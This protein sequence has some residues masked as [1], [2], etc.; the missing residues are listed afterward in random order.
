[1]RGKTAV[2][3]ACKVC[4]CDIGLTR[5][6]GLKICLPCY[7][8]RVRE[9]YLRTR[10]VTRTHRRKGERATLTEMLCSACAIVK[11]V[12]DFNYKSA[13]CRNCIAAKTRRWYLEMTGREV[14]KRVPKIVLTYEQHRDTISDHYLDTCRTPPALKPAKREQIKLKR[15]IKEVMTEQDRKEWRREYQKIYME[16]YYPANRHK[17]SKKGEKRKY[18]T[19]QSVRSIHGPSRPKNEAV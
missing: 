1:M 4:S 6:F 7:R 2:A 8:N 12:S 10:T 19:R 5:A 18:A 13:K 17:W 16:T 11:P 3:S 14:N 15:L 9:K